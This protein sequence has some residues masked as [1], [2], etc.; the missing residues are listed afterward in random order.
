MSTVVIIDNYDSFVYN[1]AQYIGELGAKPL[2]FR[3]D[4]V[5]VKVIERLRPGG[6]IIS[7]GPGNP[8]NPRD[9]GISPEVVRYFAG[10][11][12]ILGVC[13]GHQIIGAVYGAR[14]RRARVIKHG[15]TSTI[16]VISDSILFKNLPK[17]FE[18]MRYHSLVIDDVKEPLRVTA[19]SEDDGEVMAVE[20][21]EYS[22]FGVQFHPESVG[23][24]Y[25]IRIIRNFLDTLNYD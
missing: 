2:V 22:I 15:K 3:N 1:I 24:Q 19:V 21:I 12:P 23:T 14:V 9:V 11:V 7:P 25:G 5:T 8:L 13:L 6:I 20:H 17:A 4:E 16:R 10:R 18:G